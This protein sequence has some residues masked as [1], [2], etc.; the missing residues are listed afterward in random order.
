MGGGC[1]RSV[2]EGKRE[3]IPGME[4][5]SNSLS[6]LTAFCGCL[7]PKMNRC[8]VAPGSFGANVDTYQGTHMQMHM[9]TQVYTVHLRVFI[10]FMVYFSRPVLYVILFPLLPFHLHSASN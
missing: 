9:R 1:L 10:I 6:P 5:E 3:D 4:A 7:N 8:S 2:P